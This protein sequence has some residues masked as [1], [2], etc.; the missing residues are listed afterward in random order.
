MV[1]VMAFKAETLR[2]SNMSLSEI[3][4]TCLYKETLEDEEFAVL[5]FTLNK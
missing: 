4:W 5:G 1:I 2:I 3:L